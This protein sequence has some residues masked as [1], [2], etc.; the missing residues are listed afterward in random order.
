[1]GVTGA[2]ADLG[3]NT[4]KAKRIAPPNSSAYGKSLAEWLG[5][6]W[7]WFYGGSDPATSKVD[8]VQLLPLPVGDLT[9]G[10]FT[11]DDPAILVGQLE[12]TIPAGTP[13]VLPLFSWVG[14][15]YE[16]SL[17]LPDDIPIDDAALLAGVHPVLTIDGK[18]VITDANKEAFYIPVTPFNPIVVY[19]EPTSYGSVAALFFQGVGFVSA[20]LS[21]GVHTIH[22]DEPYIIGPGVYP[23]IPAGFG[24][25][26]HNTWVITVT[27]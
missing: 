9:G 14:E 16:A 2:R 7:R 10:S 21:P 23:P 15:R 22:L 12:L 27:P 17:N 5:I 24:Q 25:I 8:G 11:P 4:L 1:M 6:Y 18:P 3:A 26:F 13:F 20:P 19:P